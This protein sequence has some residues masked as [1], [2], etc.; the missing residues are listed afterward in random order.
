MKLI[1]WWCLNLVNKNIDEKYKR[2]WIF[3][4]N[5]N[6]TWFG[7]IIELITNPF[8]GTRFLKVVT[9]VISM[10]LDY[11]LVTCFYVINVCRVSTSSSFCIKA[12]KLFRFFQH[13]CMQ[14]CTLPKSTLSEHITA[15]Y[16]TYSVFSKDG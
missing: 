13:A 9:K 8:L 14:R 7:L 3:N 15:R 11:W 16:Y 2:H 1:W 5:L 6:F 4:L 10:N 12:R